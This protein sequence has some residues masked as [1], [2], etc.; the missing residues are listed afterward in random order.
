MDDE[1]L[2]WINEAACAGVPVDAFFVEAG[3]VIDEEILN[4]CRGCPVRKQCLEYAYRRGYT[5]GY[6]G[7]I[8]P[9]A[10]KALPLEDPA[11][12]RGRHPAGVLSAPVAHQHRQAPQRATGSDYLRPGQPT[13]REVRRDR[14]RAEIAQ[15]ARQCGDIDQAGRAELGG[16]ETERPRGPVLPLLTS[17]APGSGLTIEVAD[18]THPLQRRVECR[19][20]R[21]HL[22]LAVLVGTQPPEACQG[23]VPGSGHHSPILLVAPSTAPVPAV[24]RRDVEGR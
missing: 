7:G 9:G 21:G 4:V 2:I 14:R 24:T 19:Q 22:V 11:S 17:H 10:R 20:T 12:D 15:D 5:S 3:R 1:N 18:H 16:L 23:D 13:P 6:F 8:S